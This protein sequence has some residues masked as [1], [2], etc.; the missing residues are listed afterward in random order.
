MEVMIMHVHHGQY[1]IIN[2]VI[3]LKINTKME[4]IV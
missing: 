1:Q 3:A 4:M 2:I